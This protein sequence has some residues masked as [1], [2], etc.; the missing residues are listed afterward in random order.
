MLAD[1]S[2]GHYPYV[3]LVNIDTT[4]DEETMTGSTSGSM[5]AA[6]RIWH[7]FPTIFRCFSG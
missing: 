5:V 6:R 7:G 3:L 1:T 4:A 2:V